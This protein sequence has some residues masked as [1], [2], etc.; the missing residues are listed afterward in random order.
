MRLTL[1]SLDFTLEAFQLVASLV[2]S[3][4]IYNPLQQGGTMPSI[5]FIS[6]DKDNNPQKKVY[7]GKHLNEL[8]INEEEIGQIITDCMFGEGKVNISQEEK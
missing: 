1:T 6:F 8:L 5:E 2:D 4:T 7:E 3:S